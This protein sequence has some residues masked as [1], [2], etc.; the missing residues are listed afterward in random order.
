MS[1]AFPLKPVEVNPTLGLP[2]KVLESDRAL[3]LGLQGQF[4]PEIYPRQYEA[5]QKA[6]DKIDALLK[7]YQLE[8]LIN[9]KI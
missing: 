6:I 7:Y 1:K 8:D 3:H 4:P 5:A 2:R 9:G